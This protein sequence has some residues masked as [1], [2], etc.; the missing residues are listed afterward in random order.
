MS[1][2]NNQTWWNAAMQHLAV[3]LSKGVLNEMKQRIL[4]T[5]IKKERLA[6]DENTDRMRDFFDREIRRYNN[7]K[8]A[9]KLKQQ[10]IALIKEKV[11]AMKARYR[12]IIRELLLHNQSLYKKCD[13]H[14]IL[15]ER[16]RVW[17]DVH[18]WR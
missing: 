7:R 8:E 10:E 16:V 17:G 13:K 14:D 2:E 11:E 3:Q 6:L 5:N 1:N 15:T 9:T 4:K 12:K 18:S